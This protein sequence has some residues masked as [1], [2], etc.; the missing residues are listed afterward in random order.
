MPDNLLN[1]LNQSNKDIDNQKLIAYLKDQLSASEKHDFEE[2]MLGSD[3]M[4]EA[5]EGLDEFKN[6][7]QASLYAEQINRDLQ[8]K[9]EKKKYRK[10][11]RKLKE[12]SWL[13]FSIILILL[14]AVISFIILRYHFT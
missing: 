10:E 3:F 6:T 2:E 5:I 13:Y 11:K 14:L 12:I 1:I 9:L 4:S 7:S 8:K